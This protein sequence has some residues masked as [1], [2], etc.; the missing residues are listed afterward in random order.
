MPIGLAGELNGKLSSLVSVNSIDKPA[1]YIP[2]GTSCG[3][4]RT[5]SSAVPRIVLLRFVMPRITTNGIYS[6]SAETNSI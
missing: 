3:M 5:D 4:V 1:F 2:F 6:P